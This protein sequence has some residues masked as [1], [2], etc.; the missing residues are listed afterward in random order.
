MHWYRVYVK[1]S[2]VTHSL[3]TRKKNTGLVLELLDPYMYTFCMHIHFRVEKMQEIQ[4]L[5]VSN[6]NQLYKFDAT[7]V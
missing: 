7:C 1:M 3:K 5:N 2:H 6:N 4:V